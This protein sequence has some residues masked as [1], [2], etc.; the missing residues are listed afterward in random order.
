MSNWTKFYNWLKTI[1]VFDSIK[2]FYGGLID[3]V[4]FIIGQTSDQG[5]DI[6]I[7]ALPLVAPAPNAISMFYVSQTVLNFDRNQ[8]FMFAICAEFVLFGLF[9]V[10]LMMFDGYQ[11]KPTRYG[12]PLTISVAVSGA[13][14][15]IIIILVLWLEKEHAILAVL[16][17][18]SAAGATA[19]ALKRWHVRNQNLVIMPAKLRTARSTKLG[20]NRQPNLVDSVV[21]KLEDN[22]PNLDKLDSPLALANEK[23]RQAKLEAQ[24]IMLNLYRDNPFAP[25]KDIAEQLNKSPQ[26]INNWLKDLEEQKVIH[27]NGNGVEIL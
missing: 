27:K 14:L 11:D 9:E 1:N 16:P 23:R 24:R 3:L 25:S 7:R 26:T 10:S 20:Q 4:G 2:Q 15:L 8:A 22:T 21:A 6:V 12:W 13:A 18:L 5:A 19:L 17:V